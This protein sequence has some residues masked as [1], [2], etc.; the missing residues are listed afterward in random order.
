MISQTRPVRPEQE[1]VEVFVDTCLRIARQSGR[2][3]P[4]ELCE[5]Q[6]WDAAYWELLVQLAELRSD[7]RLAGDAAKRLRSMPGPP[8][9][10]GGEP[11]TAWSSRSRTAT[12][13][14]P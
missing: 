13:Q 11:A 4:A 6:A 5:P 1:R 9:G 12:T 8:A 7:R 3:L 14:R 2:N 10:P